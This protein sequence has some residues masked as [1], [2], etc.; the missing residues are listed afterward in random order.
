MALVIPE[1]FADAINEKLG[2]S[3]KVGSLAFDATDMV[4]EIRQSG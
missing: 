2:V 4:G 1:I 3:L